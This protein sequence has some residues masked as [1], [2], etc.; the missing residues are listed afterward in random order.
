MFKLC[1]GFYKGFFLGGGGCFC[2]FLMF[3][4]Q[5]ENIDTVLYGLSTYGT[6]AVLHPNWHNIICNTTYIIKGPRNNIFKIYISSYYIFI[7]V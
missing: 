7:K 1:S 4:V 2:C 5:G 3:L 6:V